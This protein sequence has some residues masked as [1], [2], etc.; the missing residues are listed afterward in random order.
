MN[1]VVEG[2]SVDGG[3]ATSGGSRVASL[4]HKIADDPGH[5]W[6]QM[7]LHMTFNKRLLVYADCLIISTPH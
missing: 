7:V 2:F 4:D 5:K 6:K 1:L 3:T